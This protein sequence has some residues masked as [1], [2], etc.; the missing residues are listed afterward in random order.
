MKLIIATI[1]PTKVE[2]VR[3]ALLRAE[4]NRMTV[5]DA[6]AYKHRS[7]DADVYRGH[8]FTK[9]LMRRVELHIVV[10]DDFVDRTLQ[11]I[12][13]VAR[14]GPEG[15]LGDGKVFVLPLVDVI[16]ISEATRGPG[17]V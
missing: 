8:G 13:E 17:A 3:L 15:T 6:Q 5:C 9:E 14:T 10:N 4:V 16:D 1:Q 11:A 2:A 12:A 7:P